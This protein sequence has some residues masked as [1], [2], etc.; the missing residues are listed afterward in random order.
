MKR[1]SNIWNN[2]LIISKII[3]NGINLRIKFI[4]F[5]F[6]PIKR[7]NKKNRPNLIKWQLM[8]AASY[9]RAGNYQTAFSMYQTIHGRFPD[10]V[11]C[12]KFLIR[13]CGEL[14]GETVV[15]SRMVEM[16]S[17]NIG[18]GGEKSYAQL[19]DQYMETLKRLEKAHE[20]RE[21]QTIQQQQSNSRSAVSRAASKFI[22][23]TR[24]Q[25]YGNNR[26][27]HYGQSSASSREDSAATSSTISTS[28]GGSIGSSSGYVTSRT[29]SNN[30]KLLT[31]TTISSRRLNDSNRAN[32]ESTSSNIQIGGNQ[33]MNRSA[34]SA[35]VDQVVEHLDNTTLNERPTTSWSRR[36]LQ[37]KVENNDVD[38]DDDLLL[39]DANLDEILPD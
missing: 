28:S 35:I 30:K 20:L 32:I 21:Q 12:L 10:N 23:N 25:Q 36:Q 16:L 29:N 19:A 31:T 18:G 7:S 9:R 8:I 11:D 6:H 26:N 27:N 15:S 37:R 1:L 34:I 2:W 33:Q 3:V 5:I 13:L 39:L 4:F 24:D 22:N 14:D 38:D 17:N